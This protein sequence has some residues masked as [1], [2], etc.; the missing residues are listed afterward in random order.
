M[1]S[2]RYTILI[3]DRHTGVTRQVTVSV[4]ALLLIAS[5]LAGLA[6]LPL[7]MGLGARWSASFEHAHLAAANL[8]LKLENDS[9][10]AV[11]G[12]LTTQITSL[13]SVVTELTEKGALDPAQRKAMANL[14]ALVRNRAMGGGAPTPS[15]RAV[16]SAALTSPED[17]FGVLRDLLGL[18]ES[19]LRVVRV[20]ADRWQALAGAT[21]SIWPV[22]GWLSDGFG[23]RNDPFSGEPA[24][25]LGLDI[26]A[27]KGQPI[28]ATA[29]G[30]VQSAAYRPD[31]GN[32][33]IIAHEFG[34][35]TRYAHLSRFA[36]RAGDLVQRG[37]IIGYV[38]STGRSTAPHLHYEVWANG[39]PLNPLKLLASRPGR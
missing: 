33:V 29:H 36:V 34:L 22:I 5:T 14:P 24:Q 26:S 20:D 18:L 7:L 10:R 39:R 25:H 8:A 30:T 11:T 19:R 35:T 32:L 31:F 3:A 21:P 1:L 4:R 16:V 6:V 38:G 12:E 37:D 2:K 15:T 23:R 17:T 27:D 9:Y 28:F 13:Q